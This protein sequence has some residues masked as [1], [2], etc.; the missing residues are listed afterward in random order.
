MDDPKNA[1]RM[2]KKE[3]DLDNKGLVLQHTQKKSNLNKSSTKAAIS[4]N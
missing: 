1:G 4:L 2:R 3:Y